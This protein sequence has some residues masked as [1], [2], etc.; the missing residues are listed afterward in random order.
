MP[1]TQGLARSLVQAPARSLVHL[2]VIVADANLALVYTARNA[3]LILDVV[4][5]DVGAHN[6]GDV[7]SS[8]LVPTARR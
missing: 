5:D 4:E 3:P 6:P 8:G 1:P 2:A 7:L